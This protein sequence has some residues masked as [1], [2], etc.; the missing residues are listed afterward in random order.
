[1]SHTNDATRRIRRDGEN[2]RALVHARRGFRAQW[3]GMRLGL[4]RRIREKRLDLEEVRAQ[5]S[6]RYVRHTLFAVD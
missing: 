5:I 4:S 2:L 6:V 3:E 1:M